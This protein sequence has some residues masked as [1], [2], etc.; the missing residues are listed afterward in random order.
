M[1]SLAVAAFLTSGWGGG[2]SSIEPAL[3]GLPLVTNIVLSTSF[4]S[5]YSPFL[6]ALPLNHLGFHD[7]VFLKETGLY[8]TLFNMVATCIIPLCVIE[9]MNSISKSDNRTVGHLTPE[10]HWRGYETNS[11]C[12]DTSCEVLR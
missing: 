1:Q 12:R 8:A 11:V 7:M 2:S 10:E 5:V 4:I 6:K 3:T 9:P